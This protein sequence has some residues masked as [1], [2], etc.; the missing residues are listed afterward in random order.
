MNSESLL[1][2]SELE[3]KSTI[4]N[5]LTAAALFRHYSATLILRRMTKPKKKLSF[6]NPMKSLRKKRLRRRSP[7]MMKMRL[8]A[9]L[10]L[11]SKR[12]KLKNQKK[13][14]PRTKLLM[15]KTKRQTLLRRKRLYMS[16]SEVRIT[17]R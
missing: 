14:I 4:C 10:Y 16:I 2:L 11:K 7:F 17:S 3:R 13:S 9:N 1:S 5:R 6:P 12:L 15:K 8:R